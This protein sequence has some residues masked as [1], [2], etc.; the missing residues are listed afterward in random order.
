MA[1]TPTL[2]ERE[3]TVYAELRNGRQIRE[4]RIDGRK[5]YFVQPADDNYWHA[6]R[7]PEAALRWFERS[8]A[9]M[10]RRG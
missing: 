3:Y 8:R 9:A 4:T 5:W 10:V 7:T 2:G 1:N 6:H